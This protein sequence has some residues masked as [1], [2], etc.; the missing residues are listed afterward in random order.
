[1]DVITVDFDIAVIYAN[2]L[3]GRAAGRP[4]TD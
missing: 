1:M 2:L 3:D 4:A